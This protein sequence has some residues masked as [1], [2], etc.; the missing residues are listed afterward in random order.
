[1][2]SYIKKITLGGLRDFF[3]FSTQAIYLLCITY[4]SL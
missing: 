1:M 4:V 2:Y 3:E